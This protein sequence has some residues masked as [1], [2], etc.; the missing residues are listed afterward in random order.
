[1]SPDW[2]AARAHGFDLCG[3]SGMV[4]RPT[5]TDV[6][7]AKMIEEYGEDDATWREMRSAQ[8]IAQAVRAHIESEP[9]IARALAA[10]DDGGAS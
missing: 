1:M 3:V 9:R 2:T 6:I 4:G 10:L 7:V 8:R 5:L